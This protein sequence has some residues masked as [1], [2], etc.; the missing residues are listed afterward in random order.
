[1]YIF[2]CYKSRIRNA[3][4]EEQVS[5]GCT[6]TPDQIP[7]ICNQN[8]INTM[9]GPRKRNTQAYIN[10]VCCAGDYCNDGEFPELPPLNG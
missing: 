2:Q 3:F 1:M 9:G 6:T 8:T 7:L 10:V 5:R 4:G